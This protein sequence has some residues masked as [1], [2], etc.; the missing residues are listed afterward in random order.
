MPSSVLDV[1]PMESD[2]LACPRR[3]QSTEHILVR[4]LGDKTR[5]QGHS[6]E[7]VRGKG[8]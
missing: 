6:K 5:G 3:V 2:V 4:I 8:I 7:K 1:G